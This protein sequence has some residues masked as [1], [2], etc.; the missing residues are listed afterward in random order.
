[1]LHPLLIYSLVFNAALLCFFLLEGHDWFGRSATV[2]YVLNLGSIALT[3]GSYWLTLY[4]LRKPMWR[5]GIWGVVLLLQVVLYCTAMYAQAPKYGV[6]LTLL[7]G[8]LIYPKK[9]KS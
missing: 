4:G 1:M 8:L 7:L 2:L 9:K 3:L 5:V 6:I